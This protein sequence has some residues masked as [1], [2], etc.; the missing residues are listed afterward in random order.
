MANTFLKIGGGTV[1]LLAVTLSSRLIIGEGP[2]GG[3]SG[4]TVTKSVGHSLAKK[5]LLGDRETIVAKATSLGTL[6]IPNLYNKTHAKLVIPI[7]LN[8][9]SKIIAPKYHTM[10]VSKIG[11]STPQNY[12]IASLVRKESSVTSNG[13]IKVE[14]IAKISSIIRLSNPLKEKVYNLE[15]TIKRMRLLEMKSSIEALRKAPSIQVN[16]NSDTT[17]RGNLLRVTANLD[18]QTGQ[19]WMRIIDNKGMIVQKAGLVK[20]NATG[21]QILIGTKDLEAGKYIVQVSNHRNFSPLGVSEF[22]VKGVSPLFGVVPLVPLLP[23]LPL[24]DSPDKTFKKVIFRTMQDSR[25]D[26]KCKKFENKTFKVD[27]PKLPIPPIHFNCLLPDTLV[28]ATDGILT[29]IRTWYDGPVIEILTSNGSSLTVTPNHLLLT[30]QGFIAADLI[31]QGDQIIN[32]LDPKG[33][34]FTINPNYNRKPSTIKQ[35]FDSLAESTGMTTTTVPTTSKNL[36]GDIMFSDGNIDV[37][38]TNSLLRN[39]GKPSFFQHLFT[40]IFNWR[41]LT[42]QSLFSGKCSLTNFLESV[43]SSTSRSMSGSRQSESFFSTRLRHTQEHGF[44]SASGFDSTTDQSLLNKPPTNIEMIRDSLDRFSRIVKTDDVIDI[45]VKT[46]R[47]HVYDLQTPTTL[48]FGN[49]I[50][51]SNCRCHLEGKQ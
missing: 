2:K 50:L 21:F 31:R 12:S 22:E 16:V 24:P 39:T 49:S 43:L 34:M 10:S 18:E 9:E 51:V 40:N 3:S 36:H 7:T 28:Y 38:G 23:L 14:S 25:V 13:K 35:V 1:L 37:V 8:S 19:I 45:K 44:T 29:G 17:Q 11:L 41:N 20:K 15:K 6:L 42:T 26:S 30:A 4:G 32:S 33:K 47:G 48:Y 46:Y 5:Q 27:D